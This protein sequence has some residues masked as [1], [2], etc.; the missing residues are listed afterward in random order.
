[1]IFPGLDSSLDAIVES[2]EVLVINTGSMAS[3][4]AS[5]PLDISQDPGSFDLTTNS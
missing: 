5:D 2:P 4:P 3:S 1:M